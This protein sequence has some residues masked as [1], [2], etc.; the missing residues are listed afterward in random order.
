MMDFHFLRPWWLL[1]LLPLFYFLWSLWR[2]SPRLESWAAVCD[3]HLLKHLMQTKGQTRRHFALLSLFLSALSM[4]ISLAGPSWTRL[5]VP[6]YKQVQPRVLILDMSETMLA[7]DLM[8]DRLTRAKFKLHDLFKRPD[9][10]Q[11]GLIA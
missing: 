1:L 10:G 8:P 11:L 2:G 9:I 3:S 6:A 7:N 4:S 5:E